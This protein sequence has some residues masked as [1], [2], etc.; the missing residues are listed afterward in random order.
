MYLFELAENLKRY[1]ELVELEQE[2]RANRAHQE[3][4]DAVVSERK[5]LGNINFLEEEL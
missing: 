2:M 3:D 4:I 5:V 1:E